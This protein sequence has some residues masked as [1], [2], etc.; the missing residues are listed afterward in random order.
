MKQAIP[1]LM[2]SGDCREALNFYKDCLGG[3][4]KSIQ[5]IGDSHLGQHAQ[6]EHQGRIFDSE[7]VAEN[8][9]FKASDDMPGYEVSKGSN[10]AIFVQFSDQSEQ[11]SAFEKLAEG[12]EIQ[13]P[14]ENN[15]GMLVDKYR[16]QWMLAGNN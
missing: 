9:R 5:T 4:I 6:P 8:I 14:L 3:E 15:F 10:F 16:V 12:G 13:F 7:F 2:F 11:K 1:Y